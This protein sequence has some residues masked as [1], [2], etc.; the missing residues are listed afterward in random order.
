M[1]STKTTREILHRLKRRIGRDRARYVR[2][3]N[4]KTAWTTHR[5]RC[6]YEANVLAIAMSYI[7]DELRKL[8]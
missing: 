7:D 5:D 2:G 3:A 6:F 1:T 8:K 4:D